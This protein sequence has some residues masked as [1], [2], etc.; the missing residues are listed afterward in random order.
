MADDAAAV[1]RHLDLTK[2]DAFGCSDGG[3]VALGW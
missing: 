1:I 3:N 2:C